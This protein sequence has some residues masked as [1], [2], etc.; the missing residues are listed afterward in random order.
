MI[1]TKINNN[2]FTRKVDILTKEEINLIKHDIDFELEN[3]LCKSVPPYQTYS[4]LYFRYQ[5]KNHWKK[6]YDS[7]TELTYNLQL[8]RCWANLSKENNIFSFHTHHDVEL[9]CVYYLQNKYP[10]YGT[11]LEDGVI[12]EGIENSV[13]AFKGNILHSITNMPRIIAPTNPRYSIVFDFRTHS[14]SPQKMEELD[15]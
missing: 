11:R 10:E 12:V 1:Q 13:V 14:I 2:L 7:L 9:T 5:Q 4:D 3:N 15:K 8:V 6:L